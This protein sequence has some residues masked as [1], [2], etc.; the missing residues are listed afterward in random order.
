[1]YCRQRG[2]LFMAADQ[3]VPDL[4]RDENF[5]SRIRELERLHEAEVLRLAEARKANELSASWHFHLPVGTLVEVDVQYVPSEGG[6]SQ[7]GSI[8]GVDTKQ[9]PNESTYTVTLHNGRTAG[10]RSSASCRTVP[11]RHVRPLF[12]QAK[13]PLQS[14]RELQSRIVQHQQQTLLTTNPFA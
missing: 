9:Y 8:L 6:L 5:E 4:S 2:C 10:S 7:L 3:V 12:W 14:A 13:S 11:Q 1:V